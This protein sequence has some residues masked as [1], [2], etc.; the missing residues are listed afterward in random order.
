MVIKNNLSGKKVNRLLVLEPVPRTVNNRTKYKCLCDCGK[1]IIVEGS[2][3]TNGHTKS[4]G[5]L[6]K[7]RDF[8]RF[9]LP[10]GEAARNNIIGSYKS[11]AKNKGYEFKLT[12]EEM[13]EIFQMNCFYCGSEPKNVYSRPKMNG[14]FIHNGIDRKDNNIGYIIENVVP[15]CTQCNYTKH[16]FDYDD[17]IIWIK[18]VY[19]NLS[20]KNII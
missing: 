10:F 20:L 17:F 2:K 9:K 11:N 18:K 14:H 16:T 13:I 6:K 4:C 8:G 3:I 19:D 12:S 15:C 7:E 1:E 5:C